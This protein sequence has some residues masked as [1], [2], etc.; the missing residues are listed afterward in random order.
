[1]I[2]SCND[3]HRAARGLP[4]LAILVLILLA[5]GC[6]DRAVLFDRHVSKGRSLI[7]QG[8]TA[9]AGVELRNAM[10]LQP[11]HAE[12]LYLVGTLAEV[13]RNF[14]SAFLHYRRA[15]ELDPK[16]VRAMSRIAL[17]LL[18]AGN[19]DE[20][21][22]MVDRIDAVDP[23]SLPGRAAKVGLLA[24]KGQVAEAIA[25]GR[26]VL[27]EAPGDRDTV[28]LLAG[29]L[30]GMKD[31]KAVREMLDRAIEADP[32]YLQFRIMQAGI[33]R[34]MGLP[35]EAEKQYRMLVELAPKA[36]EHRV[37][38]AQYLSVLRRLDDAEKV[39]RE[40]IAADPDD[41]TRPLA[42][43]DFL[44]ERR[45]AGDAAA[46]LR[47]AVG[48]KP[49]AFPLQLR[50][51]ALE[52]ASGKSREAEA[53]LQTVL[54][55]DTR[56]AS[57]TL[58]RA[59][60]IE[61]Y[62]GSS[63]R[64][65]AERLVTEALERNAQDRDALLW[66]ARFSFSDRRYS[67]AI[68]DLRTVLRDHADNLDAIE[69]LARTYRA[70]AQS[71]LAETS[72]RDAIQRFPL[73]PELRLLLADQLA[74]ASQLKEAGEA[75]DAALRIDPRHVRALSARFS[76]EAIQ[77]QWPAARATAERLKEVA[78]Q[79]P[80][81]SLRL[82]QALAATGQGGAALKEVLSAVERF[83]TSD[84]A[85]IGLT[86]LA[87]A[88]GQPDVAI[89][90]LKASVE[91]R[92]QFMVAHLLLANLLLG[93]KDVAGAEA[94]LRAAIKV[95]PGLVA[96]YLNLARIQRMQGRI[97]DSIALLEAG[98]RARPDDPAL[99]TELASAHEAAGSMAS[100]IATLE[101]AH[102]RNPAND[103]IA[104]NLASMLSAESAD[105]ARLE[106]ARTIAARFSGSDNA[107]FLDTLGRI[108]YLQGR[109]AEAVPLLRKA[110]TLA[111]E[112][113]ILK[114]HLGMALV[115]SGDRQA[116]QALLR[117]ALAASPAGFP[118]SD[119]ARKALGDG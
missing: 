76:L 64:S 56:G 55:R 9:Q 34:R 104:N 89:G 8:R 60:L 110:V 96:G 59:A 107:Y 1:M 102:A 11:D 27:A 108:L 93:Q 72:L 29:V 73:R 13:D 65:D 114:Y 117:D 74:S 111:P 79:Q 38:L 94:V 36:M 106:R 69:L 119:L 88:Q 70:N 99:V 66:R 16:H 48:K 52:Q 100:A 113:P 57:A 105:A 21:K 116:G 90:R 7:E 91:A 43:A 17:F 31:D 12:P 39:L 24:A 50:L 30:T 37:R 78:P 25:V 83:P 15:L 2:L 62:A 98:V 54:Q 10:R 22:A 46:M 5:S 95:E 77:R 67:P 86:E 49:D 68:T 63:R 40:A 47:E 23:N 85:W 44:L 35:E 4:A 109:D 42:L 41:T 115:R 26:A 80:V 28:P 87:V 71:D 58:A 81:G 51:A 103:V 33:V 75:V 101:A 3:I 118:G 112:I 53:R 32:A 19:V 61:L 82:A 6:T 45:S 97:N 18:L 84:D 14:Q 20:A 92:P